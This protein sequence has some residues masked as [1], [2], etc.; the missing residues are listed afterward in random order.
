MS[1]LFE[2]N[3]SLDISTDSTDLPDTGMQRLKNLRVDDVGILKLRD[4]SYKLNVTPVIGTMDFII[5]QGGVRYVFG[6][7]YVYKDEVL[8]STGIQ[9]EA[10]TFSP[11]A[12]QYAGTQTVTI[13]TDTPGTKIYYTTDGTEPTTGSELYTGT[14]SVP[15]ATT[16][17]AYAVRT[18]FLDS[19]VLTGYYAPDTPSNLVT[20]TNGNNLVTETDSDQLVTELA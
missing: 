3:G 9:V 10:P 5:E 15:V 8:I 17:K 6:G 12:G 18:G 1:L 13:A 20:E 19:D 14:V 11:A 4:G 16:L 7:Q 2:P